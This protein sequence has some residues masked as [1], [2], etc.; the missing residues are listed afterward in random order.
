MTALTAREVILLYS[1]LRDVPVESV[2]FSVLSAKYLDYP[3]SSLSG[4][5]KKKL[6]LLAA[7]IGLKFFC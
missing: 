4:G 7:N 1:N 6:A 5:T 3:I 2:D